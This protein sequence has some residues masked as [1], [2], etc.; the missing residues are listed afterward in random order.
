MVMEKLFL[1]Q[2]LLALACS[3]ERS[4]D[5][6]GIQ[7]EPTEPDERNRERLTQKEGSNG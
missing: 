7:S 1:V 2:V 4:N 5:R 6:L 3:D